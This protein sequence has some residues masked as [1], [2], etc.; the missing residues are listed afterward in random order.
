LTGP[1]RVETFDDLRRCTEFQERI[2]AIGQAH[3]QRGLLQGRGYCYLPILPNESAGRV[4]QFFR[5]VGIR[6]AIVMIGDDDGMDRG[7]AGWAQ[8]ERVARWCNAAVVHA[9]AA[10]IEHYEAAIEAACSV[11]TVAFIEASTKTAPAWIKLLRSV[12]NYPR[13]LFIRP[14]DGVPHPLPL[15]RSAVQ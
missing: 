3:L 15:D 10:R 4:K 2:G 5:E 11:R 9:A 7:P 1:F 14:H 13:I 8:A 6:P 12:S